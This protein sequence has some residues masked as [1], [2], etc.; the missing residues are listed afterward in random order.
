MSDQSSNNKSR[1]GNFKLFYEMVPVPEI[2]PN[3]SLFEENDESMRLSRG[4]RISRN[5]N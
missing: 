3:R 5:R 2:D 1:L 4:K